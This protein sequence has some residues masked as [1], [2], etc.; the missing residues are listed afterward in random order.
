MPFSLSRLKFL[1]LLV[2]CMAATPAFA[3]RCDDLANLLARNIDGLKVGK[4]VAGTITLT[5]PAAQRMSLGCAARNKMNEVFAMSDRKKPPKEFFD[6]IG[7]AAA[8][9]FTI[10][11]NDA[12]R[13]AN[14]CAGRIGFLRGSNIVTRYRKLDIRCN[15][16]ARGTAVSISREKDI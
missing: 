4:P 6:L 1:L 16:S 7:S 15:G 12:V 2:A 11:K 3:D 8:L 13:G 9:V 14:R 5:H 10:P